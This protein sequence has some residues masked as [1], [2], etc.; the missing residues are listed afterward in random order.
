M[1]TV[2]YLSGGLLGDFIHQLSVINE[3]FIKTGQKGD[4]YITDKVGDRFRRGLDTTFN[5][6]YDI[7]SKQPYIHSFEIFNNQS[8]DIDLSMWRTTPLYGRSW[9]KIFSDCYSIHW[10]ANKWL[11]SENSNNN[12]N[13]RIIISTSTSRWNNVIDYK[14]L[15]SYFDNKDIIFLCSELES[16]N[17]FKDMSGVIIPFYLCKNFTDLVNVI[18]ECKLFIGGLSMP[19]AV[20]D[21]LHKDRIAIMPRHRDPDGS[22][23]FDTEIAIATDKR[24]VS[25]NEDLIQL[26]PNVVGQE[27]NSMA[28]VVGIKKIKVIN[29][30]LKF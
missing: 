7:V 23:K 12:N 21:A 2:S 27:R 8:F 25:T 15:L 16:Y 22:D 14:K 10:G 26:I 4:L 19:L 1:P 24:Y 30:I 9:T 28:T 17:F 13:T 6:I 18:S 20:A 11:Y 29:G 5:D 3:I